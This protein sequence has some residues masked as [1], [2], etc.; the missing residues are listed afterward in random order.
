ME[1]RRLRK[2]DSVLLRDVRLRALQ[3]APYAFSSWFEREADYA[4]GVWDDRVTE[5]D[6]GQNGAV[7]VAV[8][9]G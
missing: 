9:H 4:P 3:D 8:E 5:S 6:S 7:F 2:D 1:I